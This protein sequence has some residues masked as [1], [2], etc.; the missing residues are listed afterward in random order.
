MA[1]IELSDKDRKLLGL[2]SHGLDQDAAARHLEIS[3]ASV[4]AKIRILRARLNANTTTH[5][6]AIALRT[7]LIK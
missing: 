3:H 2:L 1:D 5:A 6:V 4:V 7:K